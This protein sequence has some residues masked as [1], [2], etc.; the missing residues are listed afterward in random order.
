[1]DAPSREKCKLMQMLQGLPADCQHKQTSVVH[2]AA[3]FSQEEEAGL[4]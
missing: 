1:M 4:R 2:L 3:G